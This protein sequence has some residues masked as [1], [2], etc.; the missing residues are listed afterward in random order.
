M[1]AVFHFPQ[2]AS[3]RR[4]SYKEITRQINRKDKE[5]QLQHSQF[6]VAQN[7]FTIPG[8]LLQPGRQSLTAEK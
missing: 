7:D 3:V 5:F 6:L 8:G 4:D 1:Q 2:D